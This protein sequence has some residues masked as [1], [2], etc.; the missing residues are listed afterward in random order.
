[1]QK[2]LVIQ[3]AFIGDVVLATG[4]LEKLHEYYPDAC[5]DYMVRKGNE[6]L[7][8]GHPFLHNVLVWNKKAGK[9]KN[10]LALLKQ[11]RAER[12]DKVINVQRYATTGFVTVFSNAKE[13]IG[14]DKNPWSFLFT[15]KIKHYMSANGHSL[16]EIERNHFLVA[17][18]TDDQPAKPKLYPSP[19]DFGKMLPLKQKPYLCVAPS[20][21]WF[22]KQYPKEKWISFLNNLPVKYDIYLL[23]APGD[24]AICEEIKKISLHPFIINMAGKLNY[25]ESA[26]LMKGAEMNYVNDSAPMHFASA[27]NAPVAAVYCST[28]P[29][30]GYGPL[31]DNSFII[32]TEEQLSCRPCGLHGYKACPKNHFKCALSIE[33]AQLLQ[34]IGQ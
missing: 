10:L 8:S 21:V 9:Y 12:Y 20:S 27:V 26:A 34:V 29:A 5:I 24:A 15:H 17:A 3:T 28:V 30:F 31:S 19:K 22:T 16:H 13:T 2:F 6:G 32:E 25:L 33:D 1:M 4:I 23:G 11:I 18:F 14:F 7:V